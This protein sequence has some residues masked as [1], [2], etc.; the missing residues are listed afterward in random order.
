MV[1]RREFN[2]IKKEN[3]E[4]RIGQRTWEQQKYRNRLYKNLN[5]GLNKS[6]ADAIVAKENFDKERNTW[7]YVSSEY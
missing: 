3:P 6:D 5:K 2:K 7:E 1:T 4:S